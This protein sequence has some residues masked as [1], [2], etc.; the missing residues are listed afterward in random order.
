[1]RLLG[2]MILLGACHTG[3]VPAADAPGEPGDDAQHALGL[4][5]RWQANPAIPGPLT[6]KITVSEVTFQI[7]HFQILADAGSVMH[8]KYLLGW[9][10]TTKPQL[11][12]F[13]DAP[14]GVYSKIAVVM[15]GGIVDDD[16]YKIH[17]T[18]LDGTTP[19]DFEVRDVLPFSVSLDCS[20]T[21]V[22][23]GSTTIALK[24]DLKDALEGIDFTS[25]EVDDGVS[26]LH[27]GQAL[28]DFRNR[29]QKAFT[30]DN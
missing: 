28:N 12:T 15:T 10:A 18:W 25:L 1:M 5:V 22:A 3:S 17:G 30:L 24:V 8:S 4:F 2:V 11:D 14:P 27:D 6:D 9:D 23:A 16:V 21:L 19:R 20:A 26:T 29:L 13:P 7:D